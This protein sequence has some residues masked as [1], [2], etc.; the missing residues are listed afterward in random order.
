VKAYQAQRA[1]VTSGRMD[2]TN[3]YIK[4]EGNS[5]WATY[6]FYYTATM[7]GKVSESRGHTTLILSKRAD[8]WVIVL[9]HSSIVDSAFASPVPA[10]DSPQPGRP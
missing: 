3:T 7:E 8:R 9:N 1:R 4:V 2:R 10:T 5:A 6:Q